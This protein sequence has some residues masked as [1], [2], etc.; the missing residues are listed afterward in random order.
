MF[1]FKRTSFFEKF[2]K[3][4]FY[5]GFPMKKVKMFLVLVLSALTTVSCS[6]FKIPKRTGKKV[7]NICT[8]TAKGEFIDCE[9]LR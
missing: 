4:L 2:N 5:G 1:S 8:Y 7:G 3:K 9:P 6:Y